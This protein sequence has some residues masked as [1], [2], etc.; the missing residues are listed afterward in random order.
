M[1]RFRFA[2][3]QDEHHGANGARIDKNPLLR[4]E[5]VSHYKNVDYVI[6]A[7]DSIDILLGGTSANFGS[8]TEDELYRARALKN[9]HIVPEL[10][11]CPGT[12]FIYLGGNHELGDNNQAQF[13]NTPF[14]ELENEFPNQFFWRPIYCK[15]GDCLFTHS[16]NFLTRET[17]EEPH[18]YYPEVYKNLVAQGV[19]LTGVKHIFCGHTHKIVNGYEYEG[20]RFYNGGG[21]YKQDFGILFEGEIEGDIYT[22][23][24]LNIKPIILE[25][26]LL[27]PSA[28]ML[29]GAKI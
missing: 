13:A 27:R 23:Q 19:D 24:A 3:I 10:R 28:E 17:E 22:G 1:A 6:K 16:H 14:E 4:A 29:L 21:L 12:A 2:V 5:L 7:G 18:I 26:D 9:K 8:E 15:L 20:I 25:Q 11:D